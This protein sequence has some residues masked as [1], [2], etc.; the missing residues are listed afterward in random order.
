MAL[1][2]IDGFDHYAIPSQIPLKY[3]SY[4]DSGSSIGITTM[5][6]RRAGSTALFF[7]TSSDFIGMTFDPQS[8]W[9]IGFALYMVSTETTELLR[10]TDET[11]TIQGALSIGNDG[12]IRVYRNS[13][14]SGTLLATSTNA[15]PILTWNYIEVKLTIADSG[16]N[17]EVRVNESTW[18]NFTGDTK[19]STTLST[20]TRIQ[21]WGRGSDNGI[22]DLYICDGTGSANN[23][24][25]A[26]C[27]SIPCAPSARAITANSANKAAPATGTTSTTR[28]WIAIP[29]TTTATRWGSGTRWTAATFR[30][31][32][33][34]FSACR[35]TWRH[36]RTM[37]ADAPSVRSRACPARITKATPRMS[38]PIIAII[39]RSSRRIP[40]RPPP[41]RK[42]RSTPPSSATRCRHNP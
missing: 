6:G 27:G 22:D 2:F 40:T 37:R 26:M 4:N 36:A 29:P 15:L 10:F 33:A 18:L 32:R 24:F 1:R 14:T 7:R 8:T 11:G 16:G 19:Q 9:I 38:A 20:A 13:V 3:T 30:R 39:V 31:S 28:R 42:A 12:T 34:A 25:S 35:S 21:I 5:T 17:W 41:G 23:T